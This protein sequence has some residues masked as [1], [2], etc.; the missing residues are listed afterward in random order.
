MIDRHNEARSMYEKLQSHPSVK[1]G[2]KA[3]HFMD[4]FQVT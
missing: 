3:R 2:K 1:V 4:S